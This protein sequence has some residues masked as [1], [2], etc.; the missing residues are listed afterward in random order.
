MN[1][2]P[3]NKIMIMIQNSMFTAISLAMAIIIK[4]PLVPSVPFLKLDISDIPILIA[5]LASGT[6]SGITVLFSV[7]IL[8]TI[9]FSSAGWAGFIIHM[10][11]AI[12]VIIIGEFLKDKNASIIKNI[13]IILLATLLCMSIKIPISYILWVYIFNMPKEYLNGII[14]TI[15]IPF[16]II[17]SMINC[18]ASL[19][20]FKRTCK[21][22]EKAENI[23]TK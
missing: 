13:P 6:T 21:I 1:S 16:N 23:I 20:I 4:I 9:L 15:I 18:L 5:T 22:F 11:S 12:S 14:F 8:R 7:S 17:K 2:R 10:T 3:G 19:Y